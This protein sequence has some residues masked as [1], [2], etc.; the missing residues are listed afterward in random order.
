MSH[1]FRAQLTEDSFRQAAARRAHWLPTLYAKPWQPQQQQQQQQQSWT[2]W[3]LAAKGTLNE[4][5]LRVTTQL[6]PVALGSASAGGSE[7][8]SLVLVVLI[9]DLAGRVWLGRWPLHL[10][11]LS[12]AS[13]PAAPAADAPVTLSLLREG[14]AGRVTALVRAHLPSSAAPESTAATGLGNGKFFSLAGFADGTVT[15]LE[16]H[17]QLGDAFPQEAHP[18]QRVW[19]PAPLFVTSCSSTAT[20]LPAITGI[21]FLPAHV[22]VPAFVACDAAAS[23]GLAV[24]DAAEPCGFRILEQVH[25]AGAASGSALASQPLLSS[26]DVHPDG[27]LVALAAT[28]SGPAFWDIRTA[29]VFGLDS[30]PIAS[31]ASTTLGHRQV[32][33]RWHPNGWHVASATASGIVAIWDVRQCGFHGATKTSSGSLGTG[34]GSPLYWIPA[35]SGAL[36]GLAFGMLPGSHEMSSSGE[37]PRAFLV[38]SGFDGSIRFWDARTYALTADWPIFR[39]GQRPS[40]GAWTAAPTTAEPNDTVRVIASDG[41]SVLCGFRPVHRLY[42]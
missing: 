29:K 39:N 33:V 35:H 38:S 13:S 8:A 41:R 40:L 20:A 17:M 19:K 28:W 15:L 21:S 14:G 27:A 1:E 12:D 31:P 34:Q 5:S 11:S 37:S 4:S 23:L 26:V 10:Q 7:D 22:R 32:L 24:M 25:V 6:L 2:S 30:G 16:A 9:G 42:A 3:E 18:R 36:S